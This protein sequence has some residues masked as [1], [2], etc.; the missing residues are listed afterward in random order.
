MVI[1]ASSIL[2]LDAVLGSLPVQRLRRS[3]LFVDVLS[4]KEFPKRLMLSALPPEVPL[5]FLTSTL[6]NLISRAPAAGC[7]GSCRQL[8]ARAHPWPR[9]VTHVQTRSAGVLQGLLEMFLPVQV[10]IL[11]THPMFGPDSGKGSWQGLNFMYECVRVGR[12][13]E[14]QQRVKNLLKVSPCP[15]VCRPARTSWR[16][17]VVVL[18][19]DPLMDGIKHADAVSLPY[20]HQQPTTSWC[21]SFLRGRGAEWWR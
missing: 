3:T 21:C 5:C 15:L 17:V 13:P 7:K 19:T 8:A 4:V 16:L 12:S 14:R 2:S 20:H 18:L 6:L 9:S 1:L 10:D 11:C